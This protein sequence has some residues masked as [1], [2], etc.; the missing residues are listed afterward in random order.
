VPTGTGGRSPPYR[1]FHYDGVFAPAPAIQEKHRVPR[2]AI[3]PFPSS[4]GFLSYP[5]SNVTKIPLVGGVAPGGAAWG[6]PRAY[7]CFALRSDFSKSRRRPPWGRDAVSAWRPRGGLLPRSVL[8]Y[9]RQGDKQRGTGSAVHRR[10]FEAVPG[11]QGTAET[12]CGIISI[13]G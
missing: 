4:E 7:G 3:L 10:G 12:S 1:H 5:S 6:R 9:I 11:R 13:A 2:R 8:S